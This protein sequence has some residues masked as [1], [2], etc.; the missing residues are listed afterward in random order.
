M[1]DD[2][3]RETWTVCDE[4]EASCYCDQEPDHNGPHVCSCGGSWSIDENG[5]FKVLEWPGT[6]EEWAWGTPAR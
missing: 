2:K 5:N 4:R 6:N 1:R 3:Y